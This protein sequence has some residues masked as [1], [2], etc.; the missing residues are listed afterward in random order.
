MASQ[1]LSDWDASPVSPQLHEQSCL[2]RQYLAPAVIPNDVIG[3]ADFFRERH[4]GKDHLFRRRPLQAGPRDQPLQLHAGRAGHDRD[5]IAES[6]TAGFIE[7]RYVSKKKPGG[8]ATAFRFEAPLT[9][10]ARMQDLLQRAFLFRVGE[11]YGADRLPVQV[12]A[13]GISRGAEFRLDQAP[14]L[15]I[16]IANSR[17]ARSA[18]KNVASGASSRRHWQKLVFPVEIPPV[19]PMTGM[20]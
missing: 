15:R 20:R 4:L 13:R 19:I 17:A 10:D 6:F 12:P 8:V 18:S 16:A 2:F 5:T 9:A 7:K 11:D 1:K 3:P 14:D